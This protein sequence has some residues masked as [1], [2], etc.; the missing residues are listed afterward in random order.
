[1]ITKVDKQDATVVAH[2]VD[3]AGEAHVGSDVAFSKRAAGV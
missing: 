3:P 2:A 1:M